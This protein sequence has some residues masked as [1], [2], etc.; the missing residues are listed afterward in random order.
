[1]LNLA[2]VA[3]VSGDLTITPDGRGCF[4]FGFNDRLIFW[5]KRQP[6]SHLARPALSARPE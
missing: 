3:E 1:M 5:D 6:E 4:S 2:G